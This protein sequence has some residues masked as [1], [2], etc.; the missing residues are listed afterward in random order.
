M[1]K[2]ERDKF[3]LIGN[4]FRTL[5]FIHRDFHYKK[6]GKQYFC[7][8]LHTITIILNL[9]TAMCRFL[10]FLSAVVFQ[11]HLAY[12]LLEA[13]RRLF[14]GACAPCELIHGG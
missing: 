10:P 9:F 5:F 14:D 3:H 11:V 7:V 2:K 6:K 4:L 13:H 1:Y 12:S 8:N